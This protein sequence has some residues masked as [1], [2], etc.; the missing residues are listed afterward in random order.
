[1]P[2][3]AKASPVQPAADTPSRSVLTRRRILDAAAREFRDQGYSAAKLTDIAARCGMKAG[4]LYYHFESREQLV[5][6][7]MEAGT[8]R[9]HQAMLGRLSTLSADDHLGRLR[10]AI[11]THLALVL[12]QSDYASATIKLIWQVPPE[13]RERLLASQRAYGALWRKLLKEA[14]DAGAIRADVELSAVRMAILG[15][16]NWTVDWY[17]PAGKAAPKRLARDLA[18]MLLDGLAAKRRSG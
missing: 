5:E 15:A 9:A 11:E 3:P 4:S 1:M 8:R 16:L 14:R 13:I 17:R 7:V 2:K 18:S 10:A 12:E 6:A